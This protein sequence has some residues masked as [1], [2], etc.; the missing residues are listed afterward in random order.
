LVESPHRPESQALAAEAR[1]TIARAGASA[2]GATSW[3]EPE[4]ARRL[5]ETD[6]VLSFGG[7]GT[8]I[9]GA[10]LTAPLGV[11]IAGVNFGRMG[12]LTEFAPDELAQG[13]PRLLAGDY[14][15]EERLTLSVEHRRDGTLLGTYRAINEAMVGRGRVNKL[16]RLHTW[17][18]GQYMTTFAADGILVATP[19]GSTGSNF[20]AGGPVLPPD[21]DALVL[22][23]VMPFISFRNALVLDARSRVDVQ[24]V[25]TPPPPYHEAVLSVDSNLSVEVRDGDRFSFTGGAVRT[26]FARVRPRH[27]F[28]A[29]LVG[30][31]Q[32]APIEP[33]L[34]P[35]TPSPTGS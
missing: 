35:D 7:D 16:L 31:L 23:A 25:L 32:R 6:L 18:D 15:L 33:P 5:A 4:V 34:P 9:Q 2:W 8:L 13:L 21:M 30:K 28:H 19:T 10:H 26:R 24:V 29:V 14:W 20:A 17:V 3:E 27:Y 12:F 1:E 11:P 22:V